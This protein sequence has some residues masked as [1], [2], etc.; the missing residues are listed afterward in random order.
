MPRVF[1][2]LSRDYLQYEASCDTSLRATCSKALEYLGQSPFVASHWSLAMM[3][4]G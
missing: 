4:A 3:Y 2:M 1:S